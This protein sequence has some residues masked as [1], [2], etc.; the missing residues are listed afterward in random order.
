MV[1]CSA[2]FGWDLS[3]ISS[4]SA[5]LSLVVIWPCIRSSLFSEPVC[6]VIS[7]TPL[8]HFLLQD[9]GRAD[10]ACL[11]WHFRGQ[12]HSPVA[13]GRSPHCVNGLPPLVPSL[14]LLPHVCPFSSPN[15]L[16]LH[17]L[18]FSLAPGRHRP[19]CCS[20]CLVSLESPSRLLLLFEHQSQCCFEFCWTWAEPVSWQHLLSMTFTFK[21]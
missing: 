15:Q 12:Y 17:S 1:L 4:T 9:C 18:W 2:A 11:V 20:R 7:R 16:A 8:F 19:C 3:N 10:P 14:L 5:L 21:Q 13:V 6:M